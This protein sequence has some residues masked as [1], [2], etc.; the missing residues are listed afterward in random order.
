MS[1][2]INSAVF[3]G[4]IPIAAFG[5]IA[6]MGACGHY[7]VLQPLRTM[8]QKL[9]MQ[10]EVGSGSS[11]PYTVLVA[12]R[13]HKP[14]TVEFLEHVI[15]AR[16][17]V[18]GV[19]V[20]KIVYELD[21]DLWSIERDNPGFDY[22]TSNGVGEYAKKAVRLADAVTVSTEPLADVVRK[23]NPNVSVVPNSI[24]AK[25]LNE[26][27][28]PY[29][30]G[31][32]DKPFVMGWSGSATHVNDFRMCAGA[33]NTF[34]RF[35]PHTRMVFF[36]TDYSELL[37]PD[38]RD[39]CL[40]APWTKS[41]PGYLDLLSAAQIDV[42]LAPLAPSKFN[43]SK[44]NLR[45]LESA[46]LGIPVI[47]TDWGPYAADHSPGALYVPAGDTWISAISQLHSEKMTRLSLSS[48]G[49][50]WVRENYTQENT[51]DLWLEAYRAVLSS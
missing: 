36:G 34:M 6:D 46:A 12:Q 19:T 49:R 20:P 38:V 21:D 50:E 2:E 14:E 7:R 26:A 40:Q 35:N 25:Y 16:Q 37:E 32:L 13:T 11:L 47:A 51:I 9:G 48:A 33:I 29:T 28:Y 3:A 42:M 45:L 4:E 22:Y 1:N 8:A 18:S 17:L 30:L 39:R 24:P 10:V 44:S 41:V 43:E 27:A 5:W 23:L 31:T 15:Q